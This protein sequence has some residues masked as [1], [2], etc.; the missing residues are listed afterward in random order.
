M[1]YRDNNGA[2]EPIRVH[3]VVISVQHKPEITLAEIRQNLMEK[4]VKAVIPANYM[5]ERTIYHLLPSGKFLMGG[6]QVS[7]IFHC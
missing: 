7:K 6:P 4:V 5:D 3:T 1:E 2:M